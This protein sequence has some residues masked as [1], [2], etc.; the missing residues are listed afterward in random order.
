MKRGIF[1]GKTFIKLDKILYENFK[2]DKESKL[3]IDDDISFDGLIDN[4]AWFQFVRSV[5]FVPESVF[6]ISVKMKLG[7]EVKK[8]LIDEF[9]GD[10]FLNQLDENDLVDLGCDVFNRMS[11]IIAH[12][13]MLNGSDN[14]L[15]SAP[16][17]YLKKKK[18]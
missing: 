10:V 2:F 13:T 3:I 5:K 16:V 4:I 7:M 12:I 17:P 6:G 18:D 1:T 11:L 8:K 9:N 15:I 14:P